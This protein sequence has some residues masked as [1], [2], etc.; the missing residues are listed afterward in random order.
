MS[1]ALYLILLALIA[2]Q[3]MAE[4]A[5]SRRNARRALAEGG[6]EYGRGHFGWMRALHTA[7]LAGC[8][9][10]VLGWHRPFTPA[11]GLPMLALVV[12]AQALRAWTMH[13]LGPWW[14]ARVVVVPGM[15][16]ATS[17]PYR[18]LRHPN[19]LAVAIEGFAIPLVHGAWVTALLFTLAN[20]WLLVV[21]IRCEEFALL[22]H[23]DYGERFGLV[24][25]VSL[26][27]QER[28]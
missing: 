22:R 25:S 14:N 26:P 15:R 19:Y 7:F 28:A 17:G 18:W 21:R 23:T 5:V 3:R 4:L 12:G 10:E 24:P 20:A 27:R 16:I 2:L 6:I 13:A 1:E 8:A 9:I 11:L